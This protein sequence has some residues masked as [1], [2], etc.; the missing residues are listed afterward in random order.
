MR[1]YGVQIIRIQLW[2]SHVSFYLFSV[3]HSVFLY[4]TSLD[5]LGMMVD[6]YKRL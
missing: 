5:A 3:F 1:I 6:G 2:N 4:I